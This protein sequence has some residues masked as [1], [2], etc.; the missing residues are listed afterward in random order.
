MCGMS[1]ATSMARLQRSAAITSQ[2]HMLEHR[3]PH[4]LLRQPPEGVACLSD[5]CSPEFHI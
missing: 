1:I 2:L 3:R 4:L 5:I